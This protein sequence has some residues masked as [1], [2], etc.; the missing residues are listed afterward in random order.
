MLGKRE[1]VQEEN[2]GGDVPTVHPW[3]SSQSS[4]S[5]VEPH[6]YVS[7]CCV[8]LAVTSFSASPSIAS[9]G[10]SALGT[11]LFRRICGTIPALYIVNRH[12]EKAQEAMSTFHMA[13]LGPLG[14]LMIELA[15]RSGEGD[16]YEAF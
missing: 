14:G 12:S 13:W 5:T 15:A 2:A 7:G 1:N 11:V 3:L 4:T 6:C 9:T 16:I 10:S 8:F